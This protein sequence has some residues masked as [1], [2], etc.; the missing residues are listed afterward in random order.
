MNG[1][2]VIHIDGLFTSRQHCQYSWDMQTD[3]VAKLLQEKFTWILPGH[4]YRFY[5]TRDVMQREIAKA[6]EG[7]K[8]T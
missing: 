6:V 8:Q 7:M 4:G 2:K 5:A 1:F 3:L